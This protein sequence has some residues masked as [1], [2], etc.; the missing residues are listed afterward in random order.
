MTN[1]R[2]GKIQIQGI[3][4]FFHHLMKSQSTKNFQH[5][6][7]S[8]HVLDAVV[9]ILCFSHTTSLKAL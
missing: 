8:G 9:G 1:E 6:F 2:Q 4:G 3:W 5:L 7:S